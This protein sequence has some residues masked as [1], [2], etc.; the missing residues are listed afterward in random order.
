[1]SAPRFARVLLLLSPAL[2][3][4]AAV[5]FVIL[6]PTAPPAP[7]PNGDAPAGDGKLVVLVVFDQLRGD[8]PDRW[9]DHFGAAGFERMKREGVW[10]SNVRLPYSGSSTAPGHASL[11]TG[12]TPSVHGIVENRWFDRA[13]GQLVA[14]ATFDGVERVP[15]DETATRER[16]PGLSPKRLLAPTVGDALKARAKT[17]RVFS[18]A[19]KDRAAV[20]MGG[21]NPD[22]AYCFDTGNGEFHTSAHYRDKLPGWVDAFDR[23]RIVYRWA[24][25]TWDRFGP[26]GAYDALGPDDVPGEGDHT[27]YGARRTF[28]YPL[29]ASDDRSRNYFRALEYSGFGNELLWE[30]A[31]AA[32]DGEKL[33]RNGTTDL[34]CLSF[35][36]NDMIGHAFGPDSHEVLDLTLRSD[37]LLGEIFAHLDATVGA[38]RWSLVATADHGV[39]PLPEISVRQRPDA[40]RVGLGDLLGFDAHLDKVFGLRDG[41]PGQWLEPGLRIAACYPWLHLNRRHIDAMGLKP[42]EV[43]AAAASWLRERP[44]PFAVVTRSEIESGRFVGEDERRF[45]S[46]VTASFHPDRA[47][48]LCL[49]HPAF[50]LVYDPISTGTD[51]GTPHDYDRHVPILAFGA[52]VPKLGERT[53]P[54]SSLVV[55]PLLAK[56]LGIDPP[57][58][59]KEKLPA[60]LK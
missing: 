3:L 48:D 54:T 37:K 51:H 49:I 38:N 34:L 24:D 44:T 10:Y 57:K 30:F 15:S 56:L 14:A 33:G 47:G 31:K 52:G 55:A 5:G 6:K 36:S 43:E 1:M 7:A 22:G 29:G 9:K 20:L 45:G 25:K 27:V 53:A 21:Q 41:V 2:L 4:L 59:A 12:A 11:V 39:C 19:L 60:E 28:P 35:G 16:W 8:F 32:I 46:L 26:R 13:R 50:S 40:R 42:A 58:E 18:L 23:S 17:N